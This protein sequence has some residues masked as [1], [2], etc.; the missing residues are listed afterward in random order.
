MT[1]MLV[2]YLRPRSLL[3]VLDNCEHMLATCATLADGLRRGCP[4]LKLLATSRESLG[5]PG[6]MVWRT[7]S[8]SLPDPQRAPGPEELAHCEAARLFVERAIAT[9]PTF[10]VTTGNAAAV[11]QICRRLDGIPLAIE[12]AAARIKVLSADQIAARLDDSFRLLTGGSRTGLP[13][14][15]T[16][17]ATMDWSYDLLSDQERAVLRRLSVFAG[18]WTLEAAEA[19]CAGEGVEAADVLDL[20][21]QLVNKSL[22]VAETQAGEARYRLLETVR[23]YGRTRLAEAGEATGVAIRHRDWYL[24]LA[25]RAEPEFFGPG[26]RAWLDRLETEHDNLWAAL[27][28]SKAEPGG[29]EA[30]LRLA[31]SLTWFWFIR[32]HWREGRRWLEGALARSD[33]APPAVLP[34]AI[35]GATFFAWRQGDHRRAA[36]LGEQG[37]AVCRQVG[38]RQNMARLL[39][40]LG[41]TAMRETDYERAAALFEDSLAIAR[42]LGNKWQTGLVLAQ[43]GIIWP[44]FNVI[45]IAR[46]H[47]TRKASLWSGK[48]ET[49]SPSR[50]TCETWARMPFNRATTR[51]RAATLS[52][53]SGWAGMSATDG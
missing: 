46:S 13:R 39:L 53:A 17:R 14:Q 42:D 18:G 40:W 45:V 7:P 31:G 21:T 12:L 50:T 38:D 35:Q 25:E 19:V 24:Q 3:L 51:G 16:L 10:A 5:V 30:S 34:G 26:Q 49:H 6:E 36:E 41:I 4:H 8:L 9:Q 44:S 52:R 28:W 48:W 32:G 15:Q 22:V 29:A 33:D 43:M 11:A 2:D 37:L 27:E 20:I 47:S 1:E 23:Q